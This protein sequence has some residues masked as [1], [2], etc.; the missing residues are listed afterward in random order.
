M[1][2]LRRLKPKMI[3]IGKIIGFHGLKGEVKLAFSER[4]L[5][6]LQEIDEI[7]VESTKGKSTILEIE[8]CRM[9]KSNILL[10]F[11]GYDNKNDVELLKG[12]KLKQKKELLA[13]LDE[14]EYFIIDLV[15][16]DVYD[17]EQNHLGKVNSVLTDC[18]AND[19]L[20]LKLKNESIKLVPFIEKF[21]PDVKVS[22]NKIVINPI[23]GLLDDEI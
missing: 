18:G 9:H 17:T 10:K 3:T 15:G 16:M 23:P 13:D 6:N 2:L 22:E 4:L 7:T 14:E 12:S 11:K 20:E 8:S 1:G 19:L 5:K 21:V